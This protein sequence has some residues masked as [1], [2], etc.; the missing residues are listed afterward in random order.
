MTGERVD[1]SDAGRVSARTGLQTPIGWRGHE[2]QWRGATP[3]WQAEFA[4]RQDLVDRVYTA[5]RPADVLAA[6]DELGAAY[7]VLGRTERSRY[8]ANVL[9]DFES[10]LDVAF[11]SGDV[12]V[13]V[14]PSF[15]VMARP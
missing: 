11:E 10:F 1:Y 3:A 4:R 5:R 12:R 8:A 6:L 7:V 15:E 9:P 2:N 14:R 13:Y